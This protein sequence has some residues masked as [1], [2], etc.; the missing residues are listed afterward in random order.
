MNW[1]HIEDLGLH[2]GEEVEIRGWLY[3]RRS[4]GKLHFLVI[5]DGTGVAQAVIFKG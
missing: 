1:V 4:S 3:H 5:R 2:L